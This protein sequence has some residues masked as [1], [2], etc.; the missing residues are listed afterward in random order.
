MTSTALLL[1]DVDGDATAVVGDRHGVVLADDD[2]DG[3]AVAGEGLVD[4]VVDHLVHQMVEPTGV[5]RP[6]V[7]RRA[8]PDGVEPLQNQDG[9][10]SV[11]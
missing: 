10:G 8:F 2:L 11:I 6:D 1:V 4:G 7:H 5:R 3:V 9:A